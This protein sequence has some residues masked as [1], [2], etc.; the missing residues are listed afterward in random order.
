[1]QP[2]VALTFKLKSSVDNSACN[3]IDNEDIGT[4]S[5]TYISDMQL[6]LP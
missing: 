6:D 1:M 5:G 3:L 4:A 2:S